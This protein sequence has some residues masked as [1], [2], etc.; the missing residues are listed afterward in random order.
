MLKGAAGLSSWINT[1]SSTKATVSS[2]IENIN[3]SIV[4]SS[5]IKAVASSFAQAAA[6][7]GG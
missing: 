5:N 6:S 1:A 3:Y 7:G 2:N 4:K